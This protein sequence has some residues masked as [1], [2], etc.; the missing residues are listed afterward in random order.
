[1]TYEETEHIEHQEHF[2]VETVMQQIKKKAANRKMNQERLLYKT[3]YYYKSMNYLRQQDK[4]IL[5]GVGNFGQLLYEELMSNDFQT[6]VGVCDNDEKLI[7]SKFNGYE[8]MRPSDAVK[9]F[10]DACFVVTPVQYENEIMLQLSELG[11]PISK[12]RIFNMKISGL[13]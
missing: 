3:D 2:D 4:L 7:G 11:Q 9:M 1:M 13:E 6:I 12:I 5:F 8:V 10:P